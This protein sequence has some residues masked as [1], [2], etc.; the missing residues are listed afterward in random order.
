MG[1]E[2]TVG[3]GIDTRTS[4]NDEGNSVVVAV[5]DSIDMMLKEIKTQTRNQSHVS[6]LVFPPKRLSRHGVHR[7]RCRGQ[8]SVSYD[9][10][11]SAEADV[12]FFSNFA[13][14]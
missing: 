10:E 6:R 5:V 8:S 14:F 11:R 1:S 4:E 13:F 3:A 9:V 2:S 12:A 7:S